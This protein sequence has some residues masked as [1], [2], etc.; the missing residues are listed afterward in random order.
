M[1][2][3]IGSAGWLSPRSSWVAVGGNALGDRLWDA[4]GA[5]YFNF[6]SN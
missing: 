4:E 1:A 2:T 6:D 3:G 5:G